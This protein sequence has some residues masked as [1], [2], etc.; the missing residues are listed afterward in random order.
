MRGS[1]QCSHSWVLEPFGDGGV[2]EDHEKQKGKI[3]SLH[4]EDEK[5]ENGKNPVECI[6]Y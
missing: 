3:I 5:G 2:E 4:N 1:V 6:S